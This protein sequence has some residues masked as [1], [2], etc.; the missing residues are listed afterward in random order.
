[1]NRPTRE[2]EPA[3]AARRG[4]ALE[5]AAVFSV[6]AAVLLTALILH[7]ALAPAREAAGDFIY[8][9]PVNTAGAAEL[10]LLPGI[11]AVTA[12]RII[13]QRSAAGP[14]A[15]ARDLMRR[16]RGIGPKTAA[17]AAPHARFD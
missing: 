14:F 3:A 13:E 11:G 9:V 12:Q 1:M 2:N 8:R 5:R 17:Q 7:A 16:V 15:D 4:R 10:Q 6:V